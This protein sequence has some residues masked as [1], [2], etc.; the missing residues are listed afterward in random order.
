MNHWNVVLTT[1]SGIFFF[2]EIIAGFGVVMSNLVTTIPSSC[3]R[4]DAADLQRL[5]P[6]RFILDS[7]SS[8]SDESKT[9]ST[10]SKFVALHDSSQQYDV[11][12]DPTIVFLY[13]GGKIFTKNEAEETL[14]IPSATFLS[15]TDE[16]KRVAV[17]G[18]AIHGLSLVK[19][20][21]SAMTIKFKGGSTILLVLQNEYPSMF[22]KLCFQ[23]TINQEG[24]DC[25]KSIGA[26][27]DS[28]SEIMYDVNFD[29][30]TGS[31]TYDEQ[32]S[33]GM[34]S[35]AS[36]LQDALPPPKFPT[37]VAETLDGQSIEINSRQ[38]IPLENDFFVG[39]FLVVVRPPNPADDPHY[40]KQIFCKKK[41][42]V[43]F[44]AVL[45]ILFFY[46]V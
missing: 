20:T 6:S 15:N 31:C 2:T 28:I 14:N 43:C 4:E 33:V 34:N 10:D 1:K 24:Q 36:V 39:K 46:E 35:I 3:P 30:S 21:D 12:N 45:L 27:N 8:A 17:Q 18:A 38:G 9:K 40:N 7:N 29:D 19:L 37:L 25:L 13:F 16:M 22:E 44:V 5:F 23:T 41:R 32:M 42:S 11:K 26:G